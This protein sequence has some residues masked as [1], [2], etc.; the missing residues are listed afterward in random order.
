MKEE[1]K[2]PYSDK[3]IYNSAGRAENDD[4]MPHLL[5]RIN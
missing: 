5:T 2:M 4:D 1:I 3:L